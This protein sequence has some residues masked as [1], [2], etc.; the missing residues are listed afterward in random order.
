MQ[1]FP[2]YPPDL[3][4]LVSYLRR[5]ISAVAITDPDLIRYREFAHS[6]VRRAC[7]SAAVCIAVDE[8]AFHKRFDALPVIHEI[9]HLIYRRHVKRL[10]RRLKKELHIGN[11]FV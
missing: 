4:H 5:I 7:Q 2:V 3:Q 11:E 6:S 8:L 9:S 1:F 10:Y